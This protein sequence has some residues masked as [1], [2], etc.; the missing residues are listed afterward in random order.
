MTK[1]YWFTEEIE[2]ED[3]VLTKKSPDY[4]VWDKE[5]KNYEN[6]LLRGEDH[7]GFET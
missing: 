4:S 7:E 3:V 6:S 2:E 5:V 1:E